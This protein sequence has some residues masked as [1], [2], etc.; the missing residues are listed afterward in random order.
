MTTRT[1][2][3]SLCLVG[4]AGCQFTEQLF[5]WLDNIT[6]VCDDIQ[7]A[8]DDCWASADDEE[9]ESECEALEFDAA[10]CTWQMNG[11]ATAQPEGEVEDE[12]EDDECASLEDYAEACW[13]WAET[14]EDEENCAEIELE[15]EACLEGLDDEAPDLSDTGAHDG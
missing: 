6:L 5:D 3:I 14:E 1:A 2:L 9:A 4:L 15:L 10:T 7:S 12:P 8:A 13:E 11:E